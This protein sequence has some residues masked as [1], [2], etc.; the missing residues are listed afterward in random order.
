MIQMK[1]SDLQYQAHERI[2]ADS[3]RPVGFVLS[4]L[5]FEQF[6]I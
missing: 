3:N 4:L 6:R 2:P 5:L 1:V